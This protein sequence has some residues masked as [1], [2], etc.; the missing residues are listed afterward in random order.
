[1]TKETK[2]KIKISIQVNDEGDW[3]EDDVIYVEANWEKLIRYLDEM[4]FYYTRDDE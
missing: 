4:P 2:E 1:M 3:V